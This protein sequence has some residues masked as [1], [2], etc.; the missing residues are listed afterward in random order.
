MDS[1]HLF[2]NFLL[3]ICEKMFE[4]DLWKYNARNET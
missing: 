3:F 1:K 2:E 4:S